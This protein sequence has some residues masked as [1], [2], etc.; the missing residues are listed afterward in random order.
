[1]P[2]NYSRYMQ[3]GGASRYTGFSVQELK[4][5]IEAGE[6]GPIESEAGMAGAL[7]RQIDLDRF[8]ATRATK[9]ESK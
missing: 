4:L 1:M 6:L 2:P 3:L 5:A 9:A 7:F 8:V